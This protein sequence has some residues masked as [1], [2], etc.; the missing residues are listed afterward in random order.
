MA[1]N[2]LKFVTEKCEIEVG[3][4]SFQAESESQN[5]KK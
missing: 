1:K 2:F 4:E 3:I 5:L